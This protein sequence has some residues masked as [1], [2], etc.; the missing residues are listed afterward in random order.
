MER[1]S[2]RLKIRD[3]SDREREWVPPATI[4]FLALGFCCPCLLLQ[5]TEEGEEEED[6]AQPK[7]IE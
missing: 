5:G 2:P 3:K 6:G 1:A 4:W 7:R